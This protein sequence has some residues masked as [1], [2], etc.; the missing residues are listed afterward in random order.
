M[1][2]RKDKQLN[3]EHIK[4][5]PRATPSVYS[6]QLWWPADPVRV[7]Q[8][9]DGIGKCRKKTRAEPVLLS[10]SCFPR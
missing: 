6:R 10:L 5:N 2:Y 4:V 8:D 3:K 7:T 9:D 1:I